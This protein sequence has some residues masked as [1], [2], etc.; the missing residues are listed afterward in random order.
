MKVDIS[1][2]PWSECCE[3]P[4]LF[5]ISYMFKR[6]SALVSPTGQ[7]EHVPIE[8]ITCKKC[9]KVPEFMWKKIPDLPQNMKAGAE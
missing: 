3:E 6:V 2:A 1:D 8:V 7:E 5:T 9:G 4:Q